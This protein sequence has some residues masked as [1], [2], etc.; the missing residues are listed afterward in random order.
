MVAMKAERAHRVCFVDTPNYLTPVKAK[1]LIGAHYLAAARYMHRK[2]HVNDKPKADIGGWL[3]TLS[4]QELGEHMGT[5]LRIVPIQISLTRGKGILSYELGHRHGTAMRRNCKAVGIPRG[6]TIWGQCEWSDCPTKFGLARMHYRSAAMA[7]HNGW[8]DGCTEDSYYKR[9][10]LYVSSDS[11][12]PAQL[13]SLP[14]YRSY[15]K[16]ASAVPGVKRRGW[17]IVQ[18]LER[19][20]PRGNAMFGLDVDQNMSCIDNL[21]DRFYWCAPKAA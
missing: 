10:G 9:L 11:L 8:G 1:Q 21:G 19:S 7:Y 18:G 20:R 15:W 4:H 16:G 14:R 17:Q 12:T 5:G 13:Y 2:E 3:Y 6:V